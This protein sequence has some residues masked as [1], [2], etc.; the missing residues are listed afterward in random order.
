MTIPDSVELIGDYAFSNCY[1]ITNLTFSQALVSIGDAAFSGCGI[2]SI[3]I[4]ATVTNIGASAFYPCGRLAEIAVDPLNPRYSSADGLLLDQRKSS[5]IQCPMGKVGNATIPP[6]VTRIEPTAFSFCTE[7]TGVAIPNSVVS[8]GSNAFNSCYSLATITIPGSVATIEGYA[9][10]YCTGLTNVTFA[11]GVVTIAEYAF[12]SCS[13]LTSIQLPDSVTYIGGGAFA[14]CSGL[15]GVY[16]Q[17]NAPAAAFN[18][19]QGTPA[20][21]YYLPGTSGWGGTFADRP[22][23]RWLL[24]NP[25]ILNNSPSFGVQTNGFGFTISWA[26]NLPVIVEASTDLASAGWFPIS[27]NT[28]T[29]G[30]AYFSDPD[31]VNHP[32]RFYR[33]RAN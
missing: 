18:G 15:T 14:N 19:F 32:N 26:T 1:G 27:T 12:L 8:I 31:W 30:S 24:P 22:T 2:G 23:A 33:V 6:G 3:T 5:L 7:I 21:I 13:G 11:K 10:Q 29:A 28:L 20:T 25:L 16:F 4:P 17:G 9:F